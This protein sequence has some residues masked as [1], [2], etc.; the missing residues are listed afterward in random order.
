MKPKVEI[1]KNKT[2]KS[3]FKIKTG[4]M[5]IMIDNV[6]KLCIFERDSFIFNWFFNFIRCH[7]S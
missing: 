5:K 7:I 3:L 2:G 4:S 6:I 1:I